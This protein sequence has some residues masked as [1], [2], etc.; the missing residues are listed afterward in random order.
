MEEKMEKV[1]ALT[2]A[3]RDHLSQH[4]LSLLKGKFGKRKRQARGLP[5]KGED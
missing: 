5:M 2:L 3:A 1:T 4:F